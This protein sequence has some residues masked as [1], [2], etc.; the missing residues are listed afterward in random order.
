MSEH[1]DNYLNNDFNNY[2][3]HELTI[4]DPDEQGDQEFHGIFGNV[5]EEEVLPTEPSLVKNTSSRNIFPDF[6]DP[7]IPEYTKNP[8]TK[9]ISTA[10]LSPIQKDSSFVSSTELRESSSHSSIAPKLQRL[11]NQGGYKR[12]IRKVLLQS[13]LSQ[14][15]NNPPP[16]QTYNSN[17]NSEH[18]YKKAAKQRRTTRK[19]R[20]EAK[21]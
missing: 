20:P 8:I 4:E 9:F 21:R 17:S 13:P 12:N 16:H 2:I 14:K 5:E 18:G 15:Y 19:K 10:N 7:S 11:Y 6:K 1:L 3:I